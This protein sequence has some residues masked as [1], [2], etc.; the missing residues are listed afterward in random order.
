MEEIKND[1][2]QNSGFRRNFTVQSRAGVQH[3]RNS[4]EGSDYEASSDNNTI[5]GRVL[6]NHHVSL[7]PVSSRMSTSSVGF[8]ITLPEIGNIGTKKENFE[9]IDAKPFWKS[10]DEVEGLPPTSRN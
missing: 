9:E 7:E 10:L 4:S 1:Q 8:T 5:R 6:N 3:S 2:E